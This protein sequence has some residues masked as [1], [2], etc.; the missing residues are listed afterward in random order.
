[1]GGLMGGILGG[2]LFRSLGFGSDLGTEGGSGIGL[3][4]LLL[5]GVLLFG[6]FWFFKRRR[7][8]AAASAYYQSS[9]GTAEPSSQTSYG[10][11]YEQKHEEEWDSGKGVSCIRQMDP[12][13]DGKKFQDLCMD[14]FFKVQG[15]WA[16][17]DISGARNILTEEMSRIIQSDAEKLKSERK[18]NKL[19][20]IAVRA[21]DIVEAWQES[22]QDYITVKF[23]ANL[24]DYTVDETTGQVVSGS[25]TEPVKF[26]EYWT[27]TRPVG[28]NPW[29]LSAINQIE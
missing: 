20:N 19:D 11:G 7:Q 15:A 22:G 27:F 12:S 21:V 18:I 2:M 16:N 25:K 4:E 5:I 26:E 13:F 23:C 3:F 17:R 28:N 1:M 9:M 24:L 6:V 14:H 10:Q 8:V 29:Q